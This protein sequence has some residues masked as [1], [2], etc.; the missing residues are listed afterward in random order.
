M[1]RQSDNVV[2]CV[3]MGEGQVLDEAK[4][5]DSVILGTVCG[6]A[7]VE[8]CVIGHKARVSWGIWKDTVII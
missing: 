5:K 3:L 2:R 1:C 4:A 6:T 8:G 7:E